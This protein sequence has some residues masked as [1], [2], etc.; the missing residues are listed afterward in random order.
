MKEN[1]RYN[2]RDEIL[3]LLQEANE[4]ADY[5]G[6]S[7]DHHRLKM[8]QKR[9]EQLDIE[10]VK[11]RQA[12]NDRLEA[13]RLAEKQRLEQKL[14]D[15]LDKI[16]SWVNAVIDLI[17]CETPASSTSPSKSKKLQV[18]CTTNGL[19]IIVGQLQKLVD[20]QQQIIDYLHTA[21]STSHEPGIQPI[22]H[23]QSK[24]LH[25]LEDSTEKFISLL[26]LR[27][28]DLID[29][30]DKMK[31]IEQNLSDASIQV[32]QLEKK[33]GRFNDCRGHLTFV[34]GQINDLDRALC[35]QA[36]RGLTVL[37][38][39]SSEE[40]QA[41]NAEKTIKREIAYK[42]SINEAFAKFKQ[43]MNEIKEALK[44]LK[45][46][47]SIGGVG[48]SRKEE[49]V[50]LL[51]NV[52]IANTLELLLITFTLQ[53]LQSKYSENMKV[54]EKQCEN[55]I[56]SAASHGDADSLI[57]EMKNKISQMKSE[58]NE[59][60]LEINNELQGLNVQIN[61]S[62]KEVHEAEDK[63]NKADKWLVNQERRITVLSVGPKALAN[64]QVDSLPNRIKCYQQWV[65]ECKNFMTSIKNQSQKHEI[66]SSRDEVDSVFLEKK[67]CTSTDLLES[68]S[69][70][71]ERLE[72]D[73]QVRNEE[74]FHF[75]L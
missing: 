27:L 52:K 39:F 38:R 6:E 74:F 44:D 58:L 9:I 28:K 24:R 73:T 19:S 1:D 53:T 43:Q 35:L 7:A 10:A 63:V 23:E 48:A 45:S 21:L 46:A 31:E 5:L 47:I 34:N 65:D 67:T 26:P 14:T 37:N 42:Q 60:C 54:N 71:L 66:F 51:E 49:L 4:A 11:R 20:Q 30:T 50:G 69:K 57:N 25:R 33:Q 8:F 17:E 61:K 55:I 70:R 29:M 3:R 13:E 16:E 72:E 22:H 59:Q 41:E 32:K 64:D 2:Q 75:A 56:N 15:I 12:E 62:I 36:N 40:L 68:L 18:R